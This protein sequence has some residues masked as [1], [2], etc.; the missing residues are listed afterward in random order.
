M[1]KNVYFATIKHNI[2]FIYQ[3]KHNYSTKAGYQKGNC[4]SYC[5]LYKTA[6]EIGRGNKL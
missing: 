5:K 4:P 2:T 6:L 3:S 1:K